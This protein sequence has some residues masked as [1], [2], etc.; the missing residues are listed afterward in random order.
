V[1][2]RDQEVDHHGRSTC[3]RAAAHRPLEV[4]GTAQT[5]RRGQHGSGRELGATLATAGRE[6]RATGA[7]AH[8]QPEAVGLGT[9][10]VVRLEGPLAHEVLE[11]RRGRHTVCPRRCSERWPLCTTI[12]LADPGPGPL[13][14]ADVERGARPLRGRAEVPGTAV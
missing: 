11:E 3:T 13:V 14:A 7:G 10:P 4:D 1:L 12:G 5:V 6:D 8:A 2:V 9:T